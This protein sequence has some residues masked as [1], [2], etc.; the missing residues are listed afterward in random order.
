[1]NDLYFVDQFLDLIRDEK[2][3]VRWPINIYFL[4]YLKWEDLKL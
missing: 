2:M 4:Q 1:V 3:A